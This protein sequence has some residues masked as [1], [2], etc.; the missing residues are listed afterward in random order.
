MPL[1]TVIHLKKIVDVCRRVND[2]TH[3]TSLPLTAGLGESRFRFLVPSHDL[4]LE[5]LQQIISRFL[6]DVWWYPWMACS[7]PYELEIL[8]FLGTGCFTRFVFL[9]FMFNRYQIL[10]GVIEQRILEPLLHQHKLMLTAISFAV[11]TGNTFLGSLLWDSL[12]LFT[13]SKK[14]TLFSFFKPDLFGNFKILLTG[15][16]IIVA[17]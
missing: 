14:L 17:G 15:G 7:S 12:L 4:Y 10:A 11:R 6:L 3:Y 8:K 16:W 13:L 1:P 5:E 2:S 9:I